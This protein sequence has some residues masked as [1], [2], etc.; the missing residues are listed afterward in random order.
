MVR[1]IV[2][3]QMPFLRR[4]ICSIIGDM[5]DFDL[6]AA[7]DDGDSLLELTAN[8]APDVVVMDFKLPGVSKEAL[9]ERLKEV[10]A[11]SGILVISDSVNSSCVMKCIQLGAAGYILRS[12]SAEQLIEAIRGVY[13]S[14]AVIDLSAVRGVANMSDAK[15]LTPTVSDSLKFTRA[16][17]AS[18]GSQRLKQQGELGYLTPA[19]NKW[20]H[21]LLIPPK[22]ICITTPNQSIW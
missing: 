18:I 11:S 14:E 16:R 2:G 10:S 13:F 21:F 5:A 12:A 9:I 19:I 4:G 15:M 8:H 6:V 17:H 20:L 7:T 1:V 22:A 3:G